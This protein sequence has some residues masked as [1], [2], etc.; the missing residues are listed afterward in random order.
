M[1]DPRRW[2]SD[3]CTRGL[4]PV[5]N[6]ATGRLCRG[7]A[8]RDGRFWFWDETESEAYGPFDSL[9]EAKVGLNEWVAYLNKIKEPV[10]A[11]KSEPAECQCVGCLRYLAQNRYDSGFW[12]TQKCE[13]CCPGGLPLARAETVQRIAKLLRWGWDA[14]FEGTT[15]A[16]KLETELGDVLAAAVLVARSGKITLRGV[17]AA[18]DRKMAL[19]REDAAGPRQRLLHACPPAADVSVILAEAALGEMSARDRADVHRWSEAMWCRGCGDA[20]VPGKQR[21]QCDNDE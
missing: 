16:A 13:E 3:D 17:L 4:E 1:S 21:C 2:L 19:F 18:A 6:P 15:Q 14:D 5:T 12:L 7:L 8:Q 20:H 9:A 10:L 11:P